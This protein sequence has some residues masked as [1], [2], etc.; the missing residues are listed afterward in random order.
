MNVKHRLKR[1]SIKQNKKRTRK[2]PYNSLFFFN[3]HGTEKNLFFL[4]Y[5]FFFCFVF[6]F[7][8]PQNERKKE[9]ERL[10]LTFEK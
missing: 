1:H 8:F 2:L 3:K 9:R 7:L 4:C 5:R 10:N 6:A